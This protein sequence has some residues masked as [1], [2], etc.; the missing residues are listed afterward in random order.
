MGEAIRLL[1]YS[2]A[3]GTLAEEPPTMVAEQPEEESWP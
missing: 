2:L 1:Y 3:D